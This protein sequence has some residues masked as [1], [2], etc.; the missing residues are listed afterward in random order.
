MPLGLAGSAGAGK[1]AKTAAL[2]RRRERRFE[3]GRPAEDVS[4]H[5]ASTRT[6]PPMACPAVLV[7][8]LDQRAA[9][10]EE[11]DLV[12]RALLDHIRALG[13]SI[14]EQEMIEFVAL[15]VME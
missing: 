9:L 13:V 5:E 4:D 11:S 1:C 10:I 8:A 7:A 6:R 12:M 14:L 3:A 15:N 2:L